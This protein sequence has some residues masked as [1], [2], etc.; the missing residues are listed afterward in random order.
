[1]T[2]L[3]ALSPYVLSLAL[4]AGLGGYAWRHRKITGAVAYSLAAFSQ[5]SWTLGYIFEL[6]DPTLAG[7]I[8]WDNFQFIG[9]GGWY[10]AFLIFTVHYSG[11]RL[12]RPRLIYS[13]LVAPFVIITVLAFTDAW[14]HLIRPTAELVP[15]DP[16]STLVY[17]FTPSVLAI[18]LYAYATF[19]V[20]VGLLIQHYFISPPLYRAQILI[21]L[22]GTLIPFLGTVLTITGLIQSGYR[23]LSP[24]TFAAGNLIIAWGLFRYQL[25][26]VMPI[27]REA[28][29][30]HMREA[31]LVLDTHGRVVDLNPFARQLIQTLTPQVIGL[32]AVEIFAAWPQLVRALQTE[33]AQELEIETNLIG[34]AQAFFEVSLQPLN[35]RR[36]QPLGKVLVWHDVTPRRQLEAT[37]RQAHDVVEERVRQRTAELEAANLKL[38]AQ[39]AE[40]QQA[41][42]ER[43][44]SEERYRRLFEDSRDAVLIVTKDGQ[45][46]D[47]NQAG[48][49]L[50]GYTRAEFT[51]INF[52]QVYETPAERERV[53]VLLE[54][55]GSI[56]NYETRYR[57]KDGQI[58]NVIFTSS[59]R[60]DPS[61]ET[62]FQTIIHDVTARKRI[63]SA[64]RESEQQYRAIVEDQTELICRTAP[65]GTLT[66]V[67]AAYCRYFERPM[68]DLVGQVFQPEILPEDRP[69]IATQRATLTP[70]TPLI[71]YNYR[72]LW[73]SGEVRW[74]QWTER[75]FYTA[76]GTVSGFQ[77][78]GRDMTDRQ[79][80]EEILR[81]RNE[82]LLALNTITTLLNE[83][84]EPQ[85]LVT[86]IL[87]KLLDI[88]KADGGWLRVQPVAEVAGGLEY[89]AERNL[90]PSIARQVNRTLWPRLAE[91]RRLQTMIQDLQT[92][93]KQEAGIPFVSVTPIMV[94]EQFVGTLGLYNRFPRMLSFQEK[95]ILKMTIRQVAG[96]L[97][98]LWL[99]EQ[100]TE[101]EV[102]REVDRLRDELIANVSHELRTPLGLIMVFSTTLLRDDMV[103]DVARQTQF[104]RLI[105]NE[106]E[107][108]ETIVSNLLDLSR[109]QAR[110]MRLERQL[111]DLT[112]FTREALV[113]LQSQT[114][115]HPVVCQ[116]P[117]VPL[118]VSVDAK[119]IE[120]VLR[121]LVSNA[122][123]YS[124]PGA[125]ITVCCRPVNE[126]AVVSV[127]DQGI[128]IAPED[129][130]RV[131]DRFYRVESEATHGV[132]GAG[133]G[134]AV[135]QGIIEAHGGRLWAESALGVGSTFSFAVPTSLA[136]PPM[137]LEETLYE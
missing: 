103:F 65:D 126:E 110:T 29:L 1:M 38:Q 89:V 80:A 123:K 106:A 99:T 56:E 35:N 30:E 81:R 137:D 91:P 2:Q 55:D 46:I 63:E 51:A 13:V 71:T 73:P 75:A 41:E 54:Q 112:E 45:L 9:S 104:L 25:F 6:L 134:L 44:A 66:F 69:L 129:L 128:G 136:A 3:L 108:L 61:G 14:H 70:Q 20:G 39:I 4:S 124:P 23:D 34:D 130:A 95:E 114:E 32:P 16:F 88:F 85:S 107:K 113:A 97:E 31:V 62:F 115:L 82:E 78:V 93:L 17:D 33:Q 60:R 74:L 53:K 37:L 11:R 133:L 12:P 98:N 100:V 67:N 8:F 102:L 5:A 86:E 92:R 40:R 72:L 132:A 119:R 79:R 77:L 58:I 135:C 121:N 36:R 117:L 122:I 27:A 127:T 21:L 42:T 49:N 105:A 19:L 43:Q 90:L 94:K 18:A 116:L 47:I 48:L 15:G 76:S 59:L 26:E 24:F 22:G 28:V 52:S 64:L 87:D 131:F 83:T 57:R 50:L 7:K 118:L 111:I 109:M 125:T 120:Q 101:V 96:T 84:R 68:E 10:F